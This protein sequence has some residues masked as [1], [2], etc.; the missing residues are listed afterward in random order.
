MMNYKVAFTALALALLTLSLLT[1]CVISF[2]P[3]RTAEPSARTVNQQV[4]VLLD[5]QQQ[6]P[7]GQLAAR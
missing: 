2:E 5:R 1:G 6:E 3:E 7:V 4:A